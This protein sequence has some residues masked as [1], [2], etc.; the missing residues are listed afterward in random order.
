MTH[1]V[2]LSGEYFQGGM[3]FNWQQVPADNVHFPAGSM[4]V[5]ISIDVVLDDTGL[6]GNES[7][8]NDLAI[9]VGYPTTGSPFL[10]TGGPLQVGGYS[11]EATGGKHVAWQDGNSPVIGTTVQDTR[12]VG[13]GPNDLPAGVDLGSWTVYVGNGYNSEG[14]YGVW[15]GT[16]T[17]TYVPEPH[18][19]AV[20]AGLGLLGFAAFRRQARKQS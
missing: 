7:Y 9:Y 16:L 2:T 18:Q 3:E 5:S 11:N 4:L 15:T 10:F 13:A 17:L 12:T 1:T 14:T 20:M 6:P 19:Y 8:A